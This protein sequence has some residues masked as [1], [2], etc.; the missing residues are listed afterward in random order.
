AQVRQEAGGGG[1]ERFRGV[2][3][4][5][6]G[7][8]RWVDGVEEGSRAQR[9]PSPPRSSPR[10]PRGCAPCSSIPLSLLLRPAAGTRALRRAEPAVCSTAPLASKARR[11]QRNRTD[12]R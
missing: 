6:A 7:L 8:R 4:F 1:G 12:L 2:H 3:G 10:R 9:S 11:R 5:T